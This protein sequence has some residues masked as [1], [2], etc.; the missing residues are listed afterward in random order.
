MNSSCCLVCVCILFWGLEAYPS[1]NVMVSGTAL[2]SQSIC[3]KAFLAIPFQKKTHGRFAFLC[4][5]GHFTGMATSRLESYSKH[6]AH[7]ALG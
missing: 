2:D 6:Y 3:S 7:F 5:M 1:L 4:F